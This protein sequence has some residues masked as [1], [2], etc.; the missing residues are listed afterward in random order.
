VQPQVPQS[1]RTPAWTALPALDPKEAPIHRWILQRL[2]TGPVTLVFPTSQ[3]M[4]FLELCGAAEIDGLT[5]EYPT[6]SN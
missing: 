6:K 3:I 2:Q 1:D 4:R 5:V